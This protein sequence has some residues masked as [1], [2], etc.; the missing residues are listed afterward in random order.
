MPIPSSPPDAHETKVQSYGLPPRMRTHPQLK[1]T[2]KTGPHS[3]TLR[4]QT[5]VGSSTVGVGVVVADPAVSRLHAELDPR[6]DG[7]W[8]RDLGSKN[9]TFVEGLRVSGA[10]V[11][12]GGKL[13]LGSTEIVV[14]YQAVTE[15]P[16]LWP[17][18]N[19]GP[20][21][22]QSVRMRQLFAYLARIAPTDSPVLIQGETGTGKELIA[23]AIHD[24]S[25]RS[26]EPFVIVDCGALPESLI[27][28]ELFGHVKGAF[29]GAI[30][31]RTGAIESADGGTVLLDE[32]GELPLTM[33]PRLLR[34]LESGTIRRVGETQRRKINVRFIAAT[35]RDLATMVNA[36]AFREDLYFRL[37]VLPVVVP[38]LRERLDDLPMLVTSFLPPHIVAGL[39]V[40]QE[41]R[42]RPWL[43]NVRELRNFIHRAAALGTQ[44]AL[45]MSEPKNV[46]SA[47]AIRASDS[48]DSA[49]DSAP[50]VDL[51]PAAAAFDGDFKSFRSRWME[52]G[53]RE[54]IKRLLVKH[55]RN[56]SLAA[57]EAGVDRTYVYRL[58]RRHLL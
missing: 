56:V 44:E 31:S 41:L 24:A 38:P 22:G 55:E 19:F 51:L 10:C 5:T 4:E 21:L 36:G 6:D 47:S 3:M 23:T 52:H 1:W 11:P 16:D 39:E 7:V 40:I 50:A 32:I 26:A 42:K 29:T 25:P 18:P 8:V 45:S 49:P 53:E 17:A 30:A 14:H 34:V 20:L 37:A 15:P 57:K 13:R 9:G 12:E 33:Q 46:P 35:H 43:G 28:S 58:I 48:V 27:E 2:D 54:Y